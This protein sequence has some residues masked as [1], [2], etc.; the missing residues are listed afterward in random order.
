M[1]LCVTIRRGD[2]LEIGEVKISIA[3]RS[4]NPRRIPAEVS[5]YLHGP[6]EVEFKRVKREEKEEDESDTIVQTSE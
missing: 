4:A 2:V 3:E 6:K 5:L 1:G